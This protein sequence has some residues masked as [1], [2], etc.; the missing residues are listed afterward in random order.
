MLDV[1]VDVDARRSDK[2][3]VAARPFP[4]GRVLTSLFPVAC[5]RFVYIDSSLLSFCSCAGCRRNHPAH[6]DVGYVQPV[7]AV[8]A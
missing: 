2:W 1:D 4:R 3:L 8:A 7:S 6:L 5:A